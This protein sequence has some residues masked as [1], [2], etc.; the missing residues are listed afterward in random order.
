MVLAIEPS[1]PVENGNGAFVVTEE[2]VVVTLDGY[3]LLSE[4]APSVIPVVQGNATCAKSTM[5]GQ[6]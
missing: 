4:R 2:E 3:R 1:I 5:D 6:R